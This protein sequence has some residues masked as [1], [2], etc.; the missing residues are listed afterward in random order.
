MT[1]VAANCT[2]DI[3][4]KIATANVFGEGK[5]F[6]VYSEED[7]FDKSKLLKT[8]FAGVL[9]LGLESNNAEASKMGRS[10]DMSVA[11]IY[12]FASKAI[13]GADTTEELWEALTA[14]RNAIMGTRAPTGH[15][16]RFRSE[17]YAGVDANKLIYYI[18]R[19]STFVA[20]TGRS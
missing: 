11:V 10:S 18:Q 16:W 8:P 14:V 4:T 20:L 2:D 17:A 3:K 9:Y 6:L 12:A 15:F 7:F 13:G 5:T 1:D 19:W